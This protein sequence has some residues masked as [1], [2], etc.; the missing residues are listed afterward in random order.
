M[1]SLD[2]DC[3]AQAIANIDRALALL[4]TSKLFSPSLNQNNTRQYQEAL[5]YDD[6]FN[7]RHV[8]SDEPDTC[9]LKSILVTYR[10]FLTLELQSNHFN[11][12][13]IEIQRQGFRVY[14]LL[15]ARTY[16]LSLE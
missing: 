15:L 7:V 12:E 2:L 10:C 4:P 6:Y 5:D 13:K 9:L 3:Q 1:Q 16:N 11:S 14:F 8:Q